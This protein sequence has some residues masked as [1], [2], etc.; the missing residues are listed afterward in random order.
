MVIMWSW[1]RQTQAQKVQ[2]LANTIMTRTWVIM[3]VVVRNLQKAISL[4][5]K[6]DLAFI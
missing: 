5:R 1:T 3:K 2:S 4:S 6:K